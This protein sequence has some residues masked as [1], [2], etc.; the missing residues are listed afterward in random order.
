MDVPGSRVVT[1][2]RSLQVRTTAPEKYRVKPS[3]SC[4]EPGA[5]VDIV[6][7]LHGGTTFPPSPRLILL[8][9]VAR[10]WGQLSRGRC[11]FP[12]I[13]R[14]NIFLSFRYVRAGSQAS[15]QD[16]FLIMAAEMENAGSQELALFW[17]EVN[18]A[19]VMEHRSV[20]SSHVLAVA[21][22]VFGC[23]IAS[24]WTGS[25]PQVT[26][27]RPGRCQTHSESA[28]GRFRGD[29]GL[30]T[31]GAE[32]GGEFWCEEDIHSFLHSS[33]H[34]LHSVPPAHAGGGL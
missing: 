8:Q 21:L 29:A 16:R 33:I 7:S 31:A 32:H 18:K 5:S 19:K 17:K 3:S 20:E 23:D 24:C 27:S 13:H 4:C 26:L 28:Q 30:G 12:S 34:L 10:R 25:L 15:P 1:A 14:C 2:A 9:P 22:G 6:V 11:W